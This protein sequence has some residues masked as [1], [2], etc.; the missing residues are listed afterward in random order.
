[1]PIV[2]GNRLVYGLHCVFRMEMV[3]VTW[4]ALR[5]AAAELTYPLQW[6]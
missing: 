6:V 1:L 5:W 4:N 3:D 2:T